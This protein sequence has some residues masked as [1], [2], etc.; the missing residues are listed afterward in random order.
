MIKSFNIEDYRQQNS[1]EN[2]VGNLKNF[3]YYHGFGFTSK[4]QVI[5]EYGKWA[6]GASYQSSSATNTNSRQRDMG[7]ALTE[8]NMQDRLQ[9]AEVFVERKLSDSLSVKFAVENV[10]RTGKIEN[11]GQR[12]ESTNKYKFYITYHF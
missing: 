12:T 9:S 8:L 5:V 3:D 10:K 11:Y 7:Q 4:G 2:L 6:A 1:T